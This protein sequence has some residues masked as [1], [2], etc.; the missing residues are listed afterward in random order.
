M[1]KLTVFGIILLA[2]AMVLTACGSS[3]E[4]TETT[5][6]TGVPVVVATET[7]E[8]TEAT[9][10]TT[11]ESD[12]VF[13]NEAIVSDRV[14]DNYYYEYVMT[15]DDTRLGGFKLWVAEKKIKFEAIEEGQ[16]IYLDYDKGEGY[17]YMPEGNILMKVPLDTV[18][19]EWESPFLFAG[20]I[21][22]GVLNSM[23]TKG[24][25]E[26]DGK[27]CYVFEGT[28]GNVKSTYYVWKEEGLIIKMRIETDGQPTYEYLFKDLTIGGTFEKE[29]T[30][31][32]GAQIIETPTT[33]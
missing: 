15:Q 23:K 1:K 26:V 25:E 18:S 9:E 30:L 13:A 14:I 7:A 21:E 4:T 28:A 20:E 16:I 6:T 17:L 10:E 22:D 3:E 33:P 19:T 5:E 29:M 31:P 27:D 8:V 24:S 2:F 32:E 12:D 11:A